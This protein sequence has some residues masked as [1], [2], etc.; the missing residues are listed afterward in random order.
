[1]SL[2]AKHKGKPLKSGNRKIEKLKV[3]NRTIENDFVCQ[4]QRKSLKSGQLKND[5]G[6]LE[7]EK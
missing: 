6:R 5:D 3:E 7:I 4:T 2:F 1:M